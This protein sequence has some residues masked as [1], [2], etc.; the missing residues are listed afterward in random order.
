MKLLSFAIMFRNTSIKAAQEWAHDVLGTFSTLALPSS[1]KTPKLTA[2][3][4]LASI[5]GSVDSTMR[6]A[7]LSLIM[8]Q[9][10][11]GNRVAM[12][13]GLGQRYDEKLRF[14]GK[15]NHDPF[16]VHAQQR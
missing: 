8:A 3:V 9:A 12:S 7:E 14:A 2:S 1:G 13:G 11:G 15:L 5:C 16:G 6:Q 10:G 4:G